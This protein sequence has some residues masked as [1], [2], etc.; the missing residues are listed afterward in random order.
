M[1]PNSKISP[2]M[3][4]TNMDQF[5]FPQS[6]RHKWSNQKVIKNISFENGH[7][8][9]RLHIRKLPMSAE[10]LEPEKTKPRVT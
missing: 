4:I 3:S 5:L 8:R 9:D 1:S 7:G 10:R 2:T 6:H